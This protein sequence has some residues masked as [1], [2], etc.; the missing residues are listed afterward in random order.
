MKR[1]PAPRTQSN[2]VDV[3]EWKRQHRVDVARERRLVLLERA[4]AIPR[5]ACELTLDHRAH[6]LRFVPVEEEP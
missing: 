2:A 6:R 5:R 4:D 3:D 1:P